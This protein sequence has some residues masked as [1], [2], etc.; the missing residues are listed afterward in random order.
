[1]NSL[2]S[3]KLF[4]KLGATKV[5]YSKRGV[6]DPSICLK[7]I[8]KH[9]N[10]IAQEQ[11]ILQQRK[12][13]KVLWRNIWKQKGWKQE[14]TEMFFLD[15][16]NK[17]MYLMKLRLERSKKDG[18]VNQR[19]CYIYFGKEVASTLP[20]N[21]WKQQTTIPPVMTKGMHSETDTRDLALNDDEFAHILS[22]WGDSISISWKD[23]GSHCW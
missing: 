1:M 17:T 20:L 15:S 2:D 4:F 6:L 13:E 5:W 10:L 9:Q 12:E 21:E 14:E 16:A 22:C 8:E 23:T 18:E 11:D 3:S 19:G 7:P